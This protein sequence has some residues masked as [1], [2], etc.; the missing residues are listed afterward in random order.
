M[1]IVR[2]KTKVY[3]ACFSG[4]NSLAGK[5]TVIGGTGAHEIDIYG[6]VSYLLLRQKHLTSLPTLYTPLIRDQMVLCTS[7][8]TCRTLR[9]GCPTRLLRPTALRDCNARFLSCGVTVGAMSS[10]TR[11][12]A[13]VCACNSK[14]D[15][16]VIARSGRTTTFFAQTISTTYI[17]IGTPASF[18]SKNRFNLKTRVNVD[19]RG[20]RTHNPV[21]LERVAACG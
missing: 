18:A 7:R 20:L 1:P 10:M 19:A 9:K 16:Y 17:C 15:S 21:K 13:R 8:P 11:T 5:T 14:R 2:A 4:T 12:M 3:R 6:T